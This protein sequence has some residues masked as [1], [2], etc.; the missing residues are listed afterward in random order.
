MAWMSCKLTTSLTLSGGQGEVMTLY[1]EKACVGYFGVM[2]MEWYGAIGCESGKDRCAS[3]Q[4]G[5]RCT[6]SLVDGYHSTR[7]T[8]L[9]HEACMILLIFLY[10]HSSNT[11]Y[12]THLHSHPAWAPP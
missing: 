1:G 9:F 3:V 12:I 4:M 2:D 11:L 5:D 7:S 8:T 10:L 6:R